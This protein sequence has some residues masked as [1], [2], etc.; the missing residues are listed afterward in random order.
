MGEAILT[1]VIAGIISLV[2]ALLSSILSVIALFQSQKKL[3][4]SGVTEKRMSWISEVRNIAALLLSY[5]Y[6]ELLQSPAKYSEYKREACKLKLYLNFAGKLDF[7]IAEALNDITE[8]LN[9]KWLTEEAL[10]AQDDQELFDNMRAKLEKSIRIYLKSEWNRV[11][12]ENMT[13]K[14]GVT[15]DEDESMDELTKQYEESETST[16]LRPALEAFEVRKLINEQRG[17]I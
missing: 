3:W 11:K 16:A 9:A 17:S 7:V 1:A 2:I 12:F 13:Y 4:Q 5:E 8:M 6:K 15:F 10:Y 14:L